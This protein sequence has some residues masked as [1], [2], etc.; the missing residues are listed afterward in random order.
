MEGNG[1]GRTAIMK[2]FVSHAQDL[3]FSLIA[4]ELLKNTKHCTDQIFLFQGHC[5][6][7]IFNHWDPL[8]TLS[9]LVVRHIK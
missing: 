4:G 3:G 9:Q 5:G 6:V 2:G 8:Q 7:V 1:D